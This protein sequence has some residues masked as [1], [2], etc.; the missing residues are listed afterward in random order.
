M[1]QK[2]I[3]NDMVMFYKILNNLVPVNLPSYI[4]LRSN[5]RS[6]SNLSILGIDNEQ[7][8]HP[9]KNIFGRSFF[10]RCISNWNH[11]PTQIKELENID[12]FKQSIKE[13]LWGVVLNSYDDYSLDSSDFDLEPD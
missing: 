3:F 6:C 9:I 1:G 7:V 2:F 10:P 5:T 8:C 4:T 12:I 13:Y 11:L